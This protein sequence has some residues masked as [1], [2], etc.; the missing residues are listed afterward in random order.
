MPLKYAILLSFVPFIHNTC[1]PIETSFTTLKP[2]Y[3]SPSAQVPVGETTPEVAP[4][5]SPGS[6]KKTDFTVPQPA[7]IEG[8][9]PYS[10]F[11]TSSESSPVAYQAKS[12]SEP[13]PV[14]YAI[15][16]SASQ[17]LAFALFTPMPSAHE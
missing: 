1:P 11:E 3:S 15:A 13:L 16:I 4:M 17:A 12:L 6:S 2:S 8:I 5:P 7:E 9:L 10:F 14:L